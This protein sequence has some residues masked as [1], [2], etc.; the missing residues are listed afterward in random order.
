MYSI[1]RVIFFIAA[2]VSC[3]SYAKA[4]E[5]KYYFVGKNGDETA[6]VLDI[7]SNNME[8]CVS[9]SENGEVWLKVDKIVAIPKGESV[10]YFEDSMPKIKKVMA[11]PYFQSSND[12][13]YS[14]NERSEDQEVKCPKCKFYYVPRPPTW[15][16]PRCN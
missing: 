12:M 11:P 15:D 2:L 9:I 5:N 3:I 7:H 6:F 1:K 14:M 4:H 16:C 8:N 13:P 10:I